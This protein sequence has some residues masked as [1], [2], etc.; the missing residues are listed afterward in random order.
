MLGSQ[1]VPVSAPVAANVSLLK[2]PDDAVRKD[3]DL[4]F[5]D[6]ETQN[7]HHRDRW[8]RRTERSALATHP[9]MKAPGASDQEKA[10]VM[11][12]GPGAPPHPGP[13]SPVCSHHRFRPFLGASRADS[14]S[15]SAS[16]RP[17]GDVQT[18]WP[19]LSGA[20][21]WLEPVPS[22]AHPHSPHSPPGVTSR[23]C[24]GQNLQ[25][26]CQPWRCPWLCTAGAAG[27]SDVWPQ[28]SGTT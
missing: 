27:G 4:Q 25:W 8:K 28:G 11:Q 19:W 24:Q 20:A 9:G 22:S 2:P 17:L 6:E 1:K 10:D 26:G 18:P 14:G 16:R 13:E 23:A 3:E 5:A 21:S 7:Y 12:E 15:E